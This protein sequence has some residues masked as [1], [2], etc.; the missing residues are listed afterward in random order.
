M[1]GILDAAR[2]PGCRAQGLVGQVPKPLGPGPAAE[3][4]ERRREPRLS[5]DC[6]APPSETIQPPKVSGLGVVVAARTH[7][8]EM[9]QEEVNNQEWRSWGPGPPG[10][11]GLFPTKTTQTGPEASR[12]E[13]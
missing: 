5:W 6:K 8:F 1:F 2:L 12:S 9:Q 11:W 4:Q 7:A 13:H 3:M 10:A